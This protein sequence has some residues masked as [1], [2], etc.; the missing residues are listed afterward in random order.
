M[1]FSSSTFKL[2]AKKRDN[3]VLGIVH[4][5]WWVTSRF[6][7][8]TQANNGSWVP[9]NKYSAVTSAVSLIQRC[10]LPGN[11]W[12]ALIQLWS[13]L[14]NHLFWAT[15]SAL[16]SA[17]FLWERCFLVDSWLTMFS[18][19]FIFE[20]FRSTSG[21]G[22]KVWFSAQQVKRRDLKNFSFSI[23]SQA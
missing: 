19:T 22:T 8:F 13:A 16:N 10:T 2:T 9:A 11:L 7:K 14:K 12:A 3:T 5:Y 21:W 20:S 6:T 15:K 18:S 1:F 4:K 17:R 23:F